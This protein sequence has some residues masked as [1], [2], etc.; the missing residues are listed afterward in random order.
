MDFDT[1]LFQQVLVWLAV[2]GGP[3]VVTYW[4][5]NN[6]A[7][8]ADLDYWPKRL[9]SYAIPAALAILAYLASI[10]MDYTVAP[11][12]AR[13]WISAVASLG[14]LAAGAGQLIHGFQNR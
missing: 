6:V 14:L 1:T 8:L 2:G 4:L 3:G 7:E 12:T 10:A 13:G 5:M 11:E 9:V